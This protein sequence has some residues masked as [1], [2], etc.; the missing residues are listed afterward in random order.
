MASAACCGPRTASTAAHWE[1]CDAHESVLVIQRVNT[2]ARMRFAAKPMRQ[3]VIAQVFDERQVYRI[4]HYL[5]K[6][7]VQN[8][9]ILRFANG[10]FEPVWNR[11]YV[12]HVQI[13]VAETLGVEGRGGY[14]D[15]AGA[16][17]DMVPNHL[18]QVLT[19][20]AME[21]PSSLG[22]DA[23]ASRSTCEGMSR[24]LASWRTSTKVLS[25]DASG[26]P[27]R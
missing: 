21:P 6:E 12:D 22:A 10:I 8:L 27:S 13:T 24:P 9:L 18:F 2:G 7:T 5:A 15:H 20:I 11:R 23:T 25:T 26:R 14:Y 17:R 4:D 19:L 3:P 1:I 16:L